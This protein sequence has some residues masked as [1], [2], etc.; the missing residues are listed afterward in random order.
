MYCQKKRL[1]SLGGKK[2]S[3]QATKTLGHPPPPKYLMVR[4]L[5]VEGDVSTAGLCV[6]DAHADAH[7]DSDACSLGFVYLMQNIDLMLDQRRKCCSPV[8]FEGSMFR[9]MDD[10]L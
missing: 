3:L 1:S 5:V 9:G 8:D 4:P 7:T 2:K 10:V 6:L